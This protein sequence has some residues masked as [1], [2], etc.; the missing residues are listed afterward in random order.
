MVDGIVSRNFWFYDKWVEGSQDDLCW[1]AILV[2]DN[3][4]LNSMRRN[5]R[6]CTSSI[7][8]GRSTSTFFLFRISPW[9]II[10]MMVKAIWNFPEQRNTFTQVSY[11][12]SVEFP[13]LMI[14]SI[15]LHSKRN[16][17]LRAWQEKTVTI[18]S[19]PAKNTFGSKK[20][21]SRVRYTITTWYMATK[22]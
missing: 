8:F 18:E 15:L 3:G 11:W 21:A 7:F 17:F 2:L 12:T 4:N 13:P 10:C 5:W 9:L 1:L 14:T 6:F 16:Q 22:F 19:N 20:T